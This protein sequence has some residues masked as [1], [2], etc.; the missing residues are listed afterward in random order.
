MLH[1]ISTGH[2]SHLVQHA[3]Q[4]QHVGFQLHPAARRPVSSKPLQQSKAQQRPATK[5]RFQLQQEQQQASPTPT[6]VSMS[7]SSSEFA[8]GT[9]AAAMVSFLSA[10]GLDPTAIERLLQVRTHALR[11]G[12]SGVGVS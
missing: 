8:D 4:Q 10:Y 12:G 1:S 7:G 6:G 11:R 2:S 3:A 9:E 5:A